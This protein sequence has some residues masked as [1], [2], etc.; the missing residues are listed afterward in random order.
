L[1][2]DTVLDKYRLHLSRALSVRM[3]GSKSGAVS[4]QHQTFVLQSFLEHG[5]IIKVYIK[6]DADELTR[7]D[8]GRQRNGCINRWGKCV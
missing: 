6:G 4:L 8:T 7:L 5:A 2:A 1:V 3:R